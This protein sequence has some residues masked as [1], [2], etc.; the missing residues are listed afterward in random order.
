MIPRLDIHFSLRQQYLFLTGKPYV[1]E[2]NVFLLNHCRSAILLALQS[3]GLPEGSG[4]GVMAYNCSTVMNAVE[5]AGYTP[6]FLDV[7]DDLKLDGR[8]LMR[9]SDMM[10]AIIVSHLFGIV[11][12]V[13]H[14][15]ALHPDLVVIEDCAHAYGIEH[16]YGDF[17]AFSIGQGKFPSIGDGGILKVLNDRFI[18]GV[19]VRYDGLSGYT[20]VQVAALF[21][22]MCIKSLL[23]SRVFYRWLTFPL[24]NRRNPN[25]GKEHIE[26]M[27]MCRGISAIYGSEKC[28]LPETIEQRRLNALEMAAVFPQ[29]SGQTLVGCNGFMLVV[30]SGHPKTLRAEYRMKGVDTDTHFKH[31]LKWAAGFG[32]LPGDCPNTEKL[33]RQLLMVPTYQR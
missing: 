3:A 4:V 17:A 21:L 31:C 33:V 28:D 2:E 32:Y 7:T 14:I 20:Q 8:D 22:R 15:K 12:D 19:K 5:Q 6:V 29:E 11:N 13:R 23:E 27:R 24:K 10:S 18:E 30:K 25:P 26:L 1:P 9:K 16:L